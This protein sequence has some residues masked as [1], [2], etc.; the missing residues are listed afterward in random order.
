MLPESSYGALWDLARA[1]IRVVPVTGR[2]AGWCDHIARMWPVAGVVGENGAF[3]YAYDRKR[4]TMTRRQI[5]AEP[6]SASATGKAAA[7]CGPGA[8]GSAGNGD[9]G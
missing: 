7:R 8:S 2:P 5:P 9:G 3:Y 1:G 4:R 6:G